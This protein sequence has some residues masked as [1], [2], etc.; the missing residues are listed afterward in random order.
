MSF[1]S[2]LG[3][4]VSNKSF[5]HLP[6]VQNL[7]AK[8]FHVDMLHLKIA[9]KNIAE[10]S[11]SRSR[12]R[13]LDLEFNIST[14]DMRLVDG[15][16]RYLEERGGSVEAALAQ[17]SNGDFPDYWV[18]VELVINRPRPQF[19]PKV[20]KLSK[21]EVEEYLEHFLSKE[22]RLSRANKL[23]FDTKRVW[24][25]GS[26]PK[27]GD[28]SIDI[29]SF[30]KEDIGRNYNQDEDGF[31]FTNDPSIASSY[32]SS[33]CLGLPRPGG[34]IF[35]VYLK[36]LSPLVIDDKWCEENGF[37]KPSDEGVI[38]FWD[39]NHKEI[40]ARRGQHDSIVV[41]D[42]LSGEEMP[43]VFEPTQIR[44][45]NA[46][47]LPGHESNDYLLGHQLRYGE[48]PTPPLVIDVPTKALGIVDDIKSLLEDKT[49]SNAQRILS[50]FDML[51]GGREAAKKEEKMMVFDRMNK[52][53]FIN[54]STDNKAKV[55][56][57][58][59]FNIHPRS[60]NEKENPILI[61]DNDQP[62]LK[63]R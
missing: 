18:N 44:S 28:D 5:F 45:I 7:S 46:S 40:L 57:S 43:V 39:D 23:K 54:M 41:V 52:T 50:C 63:M 36:M 61:A 19:G 17:A 60:F 22:R 10:G 30:S 31:F 13:P 6:G 2:P 34:A 35:P 37:S 9:E 38:S 59:M 32:A 21:V 27:F 29:E 49:L 51:D 55:L 26:I 12:E 58:L 24:Y 62:T 16:H 11:L 47:F 56:A 33:D 53:D 48:K 15:Y 25:H 8:D 1:L 14:G 42:I 20:E 3:V 4:F